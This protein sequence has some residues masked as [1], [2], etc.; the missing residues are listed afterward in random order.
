VEIAQA[1]RDVRM[2]FIGGFAGQLVSA[3]IWLVSAALATWRSPTSG[4]MLLVVAGF[5][6]FPLTQLTLRV[7]G[8]AGA[9]PKGHPMNALAMQIAFVLP[10]ML[11]LV[12][13]ATAYR[14]T[15]FYPAFMLALG[16]HYLPFIFLY[17]MW[18][19]GVL[20]VLLIG[21]AVFLALFA[22]TMFAL[23]GW[24]SALFLIVFAFLGRWVAA[25]D[26]VTV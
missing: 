21:S 22:P 11:P 13:A 20:A 1:Q 23:G 6:I 4:M 25:R 26:S 19:F 8:K 3:L 14:R 15:W 7:M 9:L 16:A 17:G 10:L 12:F 18:Q 24:I 2:T 5:F